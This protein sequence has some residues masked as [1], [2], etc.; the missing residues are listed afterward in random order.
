M[1]EQLLGQRVLHVMTDSDGTLR[2]G[3]IFVTTSGGVWL[4]VLWSDGVVVEATLE[5]RDVFP[6]APT[7][8]PDD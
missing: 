4:R 2:N 7:D 5:V 6:G 1:I 8:H 3:L